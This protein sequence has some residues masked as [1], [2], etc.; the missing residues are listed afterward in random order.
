MTSNDKQIDLLMR[1]YAQAKPDVPASAHLDADELSAFAGGSLPAAARAHYI[2]HLAD[3]DDCRKQASALVISAGAV[4][5]NEEIVAETKSDRT[6]WQAIAGLFA[7]PVLRYAAFGAVVL[8]VAGI[9]F[10]ALRRPAQRR[11]AELVASN[12]PANQQP[13]SAVKPPA[14]SGIT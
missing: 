5:R 3:C 7:L 13:A 6:F 1:R 8:I 9:A 14:D 2:S 11:A 10:V 12:E 4:I